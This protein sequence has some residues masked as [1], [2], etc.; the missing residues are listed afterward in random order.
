VRY[1]DILGIPDAEEITV[2][3]SDPVGAFNFVVTIGDVAVGFA[4][5]SGLGCEIHYGADDADGPIDMRPR[6]AVT[7]VHLRRGIS[8]DRFLWSWF[9]SVMR[10][11]DEPRTVT[12][13]VLDAASEPHCSWELTEARPI[14]YLGPHLIATV[15]APAMEEV[16]LRADAIVFRPRP[17]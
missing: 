2:A 16:V 9:E 14:R 13:T 11:S 3:D 8:G 5:V 1:G 4:E 6:F 17:A 15:V 10:G 12:V 7:D